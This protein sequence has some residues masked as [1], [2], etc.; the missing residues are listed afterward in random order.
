MEGV[1][2]LEPELA[3]V[4][5]VQR[6]YWPVEETEPGPVA[7]LKLELVLVAVVLELVL[8]QRLLRP[9]VHLQQKFIV[10]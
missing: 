5:D 4:G 1:V 6:C 3:T 7:R 8:V 2:E 10:L 9:F